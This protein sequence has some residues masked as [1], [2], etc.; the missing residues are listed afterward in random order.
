MF[1]FL[2]PLLTSPWRRKT[3][4]ADGMRTKIV[5]AEPFK[6]FDWN[7]KVEPKAV[8]CP[9]LEIQKKNVMLNVK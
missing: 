7:R 8:G 5:E 4:Y 1:P 3:C 9:K 2:P 6:S